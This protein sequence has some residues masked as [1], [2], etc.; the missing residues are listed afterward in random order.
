[1]DTDCP[2]ICADAR[3][4]VLGGVIALMRLVATPLWKR[5][6]LMGEPKFP[7]P[8]WPDV[9]NIESK[10]HACGKVVAN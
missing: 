9:R 5:V 8:D 2:V 7:N 3:V 6:M 4:F 10:V 1:M